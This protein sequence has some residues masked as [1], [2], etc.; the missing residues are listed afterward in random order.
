MVHFSDSFGQFLQQGFIRILF[1][2]K[3]GRILA[4][5][6]RAPLHGGI[7][8][9]SRIHDFDGIDLKPHRLQIPQNARR[10]S[11]SFSVPRISDF[12]AGSDE[13]FFFISCIIS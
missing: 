10:G 2:G 11:A 8:F 3:T 5:S 6:V 7:H 1:P 13:A 9:F 4:A 12:R